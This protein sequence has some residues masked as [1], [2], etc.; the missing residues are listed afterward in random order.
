MPER[1]VEEVLHANCALAARGLAPL[2]WGN[3][4]GIERDRGLVV[5]KPSGVAYDGMVARDTRS[6]P[7]ISSASTDPGPT[8]GS[9]HD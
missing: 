9:R 7:S 6:G 8:T 3:A 2:T 4:S 1:L 5:I